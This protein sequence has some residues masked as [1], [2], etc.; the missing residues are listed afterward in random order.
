MLEELKETTYKNG[1][2][3]N[4]FSPENINKDIT[5]GTM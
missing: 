5:K 1:N 2:H 3:E 4:N